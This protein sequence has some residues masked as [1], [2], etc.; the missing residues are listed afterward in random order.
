MS[1]NGGPGYR[2]HPNYRVDIHPINS[3]VEIELD[4]I[5]V[6]RTTSA[7]EVLETHHRPVIYVPKSDIGPEYVHA[8]DTETYCPFK[9]FASYWSLK[10]NDRRVE[11]VFWFYAQ[12]FDEVFKLAEYVGVYANRVD[13]IRRDGEMV[14]RRAPGMIGQHNVG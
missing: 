13:A 11:D 6:C 2:E 5:V 14:D 12:P 9:G 10:V 4:D 7:L 8:S 3:T 1:G